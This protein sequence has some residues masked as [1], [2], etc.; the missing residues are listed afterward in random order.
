MWVADLLIKR[1][2]VV[3]LQQFKQWRV[4]GA[5]AFKP[6]EQ[7]AS[8]STNTFVWLAGQISVLFLPVKAFANVEMISSLLGTAVVPRLLDG[9]MVLQSS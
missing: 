3:K 2:Q 4:G 7:S 5:S 1:S 9:Y 6:A 8:R